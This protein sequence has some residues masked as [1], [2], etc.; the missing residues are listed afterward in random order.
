MPRPSPA[1]LSAR[2][3]QLR[4]RLHFLLTHAQG[5]LHG[6]LI[7]MARR[8]GNPKC[9]CASSDQHKHRS[10]YL[11]RTRNGK[12]SMVYIPKALEPEIRQWIDDFQQA[13]ALL[14]ELNVEARERLQ[15]SKRRQ[16]SKTKPAAK[17][18]RGKNKPPPKKS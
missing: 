18:A 3:R 11:G 15:Q 12:P 4:S 17:K 14:E 13:L 10:F 5:F 6:S 2:E 16:P 7:E 9:R 8:C 1:S